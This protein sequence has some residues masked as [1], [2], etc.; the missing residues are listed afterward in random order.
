ML[1]PAPIDLSKA[2]KLK[3][4]VVQSESWS[5]EWITMTLQTM[6]PKNQDLRHISIRL[7]LVYVD[8]GLGKTID[9]QWLDLDRCLVQF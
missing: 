3:D 9:R 7:L 8:T 2:T 4:V 1:R 5:T 6:T